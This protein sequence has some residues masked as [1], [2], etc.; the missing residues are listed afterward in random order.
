MKCHFPIHSKVAWQSSSRYVH[1]HILCSCLGVRMVDLREWSPQW[2]CLITWAVWECGPA[3]ARDSGGKLPVCL[4]VLQW[5]K[6]FDGHAPWWPSQKVM[7]ST[8]DS[9][10]FLTSYLELEESYSVRKIRLSGGVARIIMAKVFPLALW[11]D[12]ADLNS[13]NNNTHF[14]AC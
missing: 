9:S 13:R 11:I 7:C 1:L 2:G 14:P 5:R 10:I 3:A 4:P 8:T 6:F 12:K